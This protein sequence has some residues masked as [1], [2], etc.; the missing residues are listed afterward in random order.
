MIQRKTRESKGKGK[1]SPFLGKRDTDR[2]TSFRKGEPADM[3]RLY[4]RVIVQKEN[5]CD[6]WDPPECLFH[7]KGA[8]KLGSKCAFEQTE[9]AGSEPKKLFFW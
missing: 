9:K 5:A 4:K 2:K 6:D 8:C 7:E 1:D 3:L